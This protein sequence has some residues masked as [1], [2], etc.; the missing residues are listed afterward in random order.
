MV[1]QLGEKDRATA[2][3]SSLITLSGD[4]PGNVCPVTIIV[5]WVIVRHG[6]SV[7]PVPIPYEVITTK[8]LEAWT[9]TTTQLS[10][11]ESVNYHKRS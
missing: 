9:D 8:N 10:H 6:R 5:H 2:Y 1:G 11:F 4:D 7:W 3:G